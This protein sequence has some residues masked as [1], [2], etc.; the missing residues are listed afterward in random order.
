MTGPAGIGLDLLAQRPNVDGDGGWAA[1]EVLVPEGIQQI[2]AAKNFARVGDQ[3][4]QQVEFFGRELDL[5]AANPEAAVGGIEL[6]F[7][8][9][10]A[11]IGRRL[12]VESHAAQLG[13]HA[14]NELPWAEGFDHVVVGADAQAADAIGFFGARRQ[15]DDRDSDVRLPELL[16][17][18]QAVH[19]GQHD[20]EDDDLRRMFLIQRR[21]EPLWAGASGD[22]GEAITPQVAPHNFDD[23]RLIVDHQYVLLWGCQSH[24]SRARIGALS[25]LK[26]AIVT[27]ITNE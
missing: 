12:G 2:V 10:Q 19:A 3:I 23:H 20:V 25:A 14:R 24:C 6:D 21:I 27:N 1:D 17:D 26:I 18:F 15:Q 22:D 4:M 7:A 5:L 9:A 13:L 16:A 8:A 11:S